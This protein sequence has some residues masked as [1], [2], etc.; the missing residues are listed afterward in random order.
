MYVCMCVRGACI[1]A[2]SSPSSFSSQ[3]KL[4]TAH[5]TFACTFFRCGHFSVPHR[6]RDLNRIQIPWRQVQ[7]HS[8]ATD[9]QPGSLKPRHGPALK[10]LPSRRPEPA[11]AAASPICPCCPQRFNVSSRASPTA[12]VDDCLRKA[13]E[14]RLRDRMECRVIQTRKSTTY[15]SSFAFGPFVVGAGAGA[16][17]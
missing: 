2:G 17:L 16:A 1:Q 9:T 15:P 6:V 7:K 11:A 5:R 13:R 3:P 10:P 4:D 8:F 12:G 14:R